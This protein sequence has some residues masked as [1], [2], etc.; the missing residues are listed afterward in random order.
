MAKVL[1]PNH[2]A[3][4]KATHEV[5]GALRDVNLDISFAMNDWDDPDRVNFFLRRA[6]VDSTAAVGL[7]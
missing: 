2:L 7:E 4:M 5:V 1:D 3:L 6:Q